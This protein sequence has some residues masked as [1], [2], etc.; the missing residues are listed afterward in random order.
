MLV[1]TQTVTRYKQNYALFVYRML[2][3]SRMA[4]S[5]ELRAVLVKEVR[6]LY[7]IMCLTIYGQVKN[8]ITTLIDWAVALGS[9]ITLEVFKEMYQTKLNELQLHELNPPRFVFTFTVIWDSIHLLCMMGD[10]IIVNRTKYEYSTVMSCIHNLKSVFYNIFVVLFCPIC[11]KHYLITDPFP[12][13]FEKVEVALY[14]EKMGEPIQ[15]VEEIIRNYSHKNVLL[16]N[17]LVY[18]SMEFHNHVN[19][20]RPIQHAKDALNDFQRMEWGLYKTLLGLL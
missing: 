2:D 15:L 19:G 3:M 14:R 13:E 4:P 9:D 18:K 20:Y 6:F 5:P 1:E 8:N 16:K 10:D 7:N 12:Y 17:C 11:A